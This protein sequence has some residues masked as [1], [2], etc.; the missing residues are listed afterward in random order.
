MAYVH[1]TNDRIVQMTANNAP[2]PYVASASSE[3]SATYAAWKAFDHLSANANDLWDA[4]LNTPTGWLK[5]D[6]A[7][8]LYAINGYG[9]HAIS[10]YTG[11]SPTAWT[12][13]GSND[14]TAWTVLDTRFGISWSADEKKIFTFTNFVRFRYYRINVSASGS[15]ELIISSLEMYDIYVILNS[16]QRIPHDTTRYS[17]NPVELI[18]ITDRQR[19][20]TVFGTATKVSPIMTANNAPTPYIVSADS[21]VATAYAAWKA[22][23]GANSLDTD[24]W[25][26]TSLPG[27]WKIDLASNICVNGYKISGYFSNFYYPTAWTFEGSNDN[28]TW[29][30][31]DTKTGQTLS[32]T[33][34]SLYSFSNTTSYRYYR[35]VITANTDGVGPRVGEIELYGI[36][37]TKHNYIGA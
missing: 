33:L 7:S 4:G 9:I 19:I 25:A 17:N 36:P 24:I 23:N 6:F 10:A 35:F 32:G 30:V 12:F 28:S 13:E 5:Y 22:M 1:S 37:I 27:W 31:L 11:Y 2:S 21:E 14:N 20:G 15:T 8:A 3:Y 29:V 16:L 18:K 26:G 34:S